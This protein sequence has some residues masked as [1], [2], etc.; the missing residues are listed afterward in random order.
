MTYKTLWNKFLGK[1]EETE[2]EK[3]SGFDNISDF[4]KSM[5]SLIVEHFKYSLGKE[6]F[7]ESFVIWVNN[8]VPQCQ[9]EIREKDFEKSLRTALENR[10]LWAASRAKMVFKAENPDTA[11]GFPEL[12]NDKIAGIFIQRIDPS[13]KTGGKIPTKAKI[14]V[15]KNRGSLAE[16][17]YFLD[18]AGQ[19]EY[20]I[21]RDD[22]NDN[23]IVIRESDPEHSENVY[24]GRRHAKIV[25]VEDCGFCLQLRK[26]NH[27][28]IIKRNTQR[29]ADIT[30]TNTKRLLKNKDE[31]ELGKKVSLLFEIIE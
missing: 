30:E 23:H 18:A 10:Q 6:A 11:A 25:F 15:L 1:P 28:T 4:R 8:G 31:I 19:T 22:D 26:E 27:R 5:L 20:N 3:P 24:V 16:T 21:G 2:E 12:K 13:E 7:A 14:S 9:S 17:E 29:V